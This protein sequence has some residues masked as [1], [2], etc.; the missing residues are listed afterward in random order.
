MTT[1]SQIPDLLAGTGC[2]PYG[3]FPTTLE[4]VERRFV[5]SMPND[6]G[7]RR[8]L[9]DDFERATKAIRSVTPVAAAWVGGSFVSNRPRPSDIDVVYLVRANE[10]DTKTDDEKK[11]LNIFRGEHKLFAKGMMVD[12]YVID[13]RPRGS[14]TPADYISKMNLAHRGYWD[15]WFQRDRVAGAPET[16]PNNAI[17]RRG[18]LEV[19]LDGYTV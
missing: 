18:Y 7:H 11:R 4:A 16:D 19:L 3:R 15:D 10:Y 2:L 17:P 1:V 9:W 14:Q 5:S 13:W 6:G 8:K 12:S